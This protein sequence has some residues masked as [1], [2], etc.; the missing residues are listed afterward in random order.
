MCVL[1]LGY[2][3]FPQEERSLGYWKLLLAGLSLLPTWSWAVTAPYL[4]LCPLPHHCEGQLQPRG[5]A[6]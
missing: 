3:E 4:R 6:F 1:A 2:G 5:G